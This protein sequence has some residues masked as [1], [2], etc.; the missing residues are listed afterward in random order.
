MLLLVLGL[1]LTAA[2]NAAAVELNVG[3]EANFTTYALDD[4]DALCIDG[5][6]ASVNAWINPASR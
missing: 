2:A 3:D 1:R 5:T 6:P 4:P